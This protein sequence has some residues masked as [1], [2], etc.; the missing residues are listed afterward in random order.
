MD[1]DVFAAM[2][3]DTLFQSIGAAIV[4]VISAEDW[5][6]AE[7]TAEIEE[8]DNGVLY[9]SYATITSPDRLEDIEIIFELYNAMNE[10][11]NRMQRSE[12][13]SWIKATFVLQ[14][15]GQF[16]LKFIYPNAHKGNDNE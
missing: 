7:I 1:E 6:T 3:D 15:T 16:D 13:R 11:R 2:S 10:L 9:G 4:S 12:H 8:D 14:N 5:L